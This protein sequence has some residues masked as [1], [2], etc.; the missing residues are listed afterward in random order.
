LPFRQEAVFHLFM[1]DVEIS[2]EG[3]DEKQNTRRK[4]NGTLEKHKG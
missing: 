4:D 3:D 1:G 2:N